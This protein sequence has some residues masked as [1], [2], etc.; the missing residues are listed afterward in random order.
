MKALK[1]TKSL[2][3]VELSRLS[4]S[5]PQYINLQ[6]Q[7]SKK[8]KRA[9][10]KMSPINEEGNKLLKRGCVTMHRIMK[11]KITRTKK[12]VSFNAKGEAFG[13][14]AVEMQSYIGVLARTKSPIW[15]NSWKQVTNDTKNE[16][17]DSVQVSDTHT[18]NIYIGLFILNRHARTLIFLFIKFV[19]CITNNNLHFLTL[20]L[21]L[22]YLD[23]IRRAPN[24]KDD[25]IEFSW[26][27]VEGVQ[28]STDKKICSSISRTL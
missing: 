9:N 16:I 19:L 24:I 3:V 21:L 5:S 28:V 27:K 2:H 20:I 26:S 8:R 15:H 17:W 23:G 18:Q 25:G 22:M 1:K 11:Y 12:T 7:L 4:K 14:E 6:K 13:P 10:S